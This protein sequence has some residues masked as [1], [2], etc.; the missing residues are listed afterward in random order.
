MPDLLEV[1]DVGPIVAGVLFTQMGAL[2]PLKSRDDLFGACLSTAQIIDSIQPD[3]G[4]NA[5]QSKHIPLQRGGS[6]TCRLVL[7][8]WDRTDRLIAADPGIDY[9]QFGSKGGMHAGRQEIRPAVLSVEGRVH[10]I[11]D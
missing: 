3:H 4:G 5:R 1:P 8:V 10:T 2:A 7:I 11:R 9:R 6:A